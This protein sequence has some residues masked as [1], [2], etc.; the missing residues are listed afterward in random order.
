MITTAKRLLIVAGIAAVLL[1]AM[2]SAS[3]AQKGGAKNKPAAKNRPVAGT[4]AEYGQLAQ[5]REAV[6]RLAYVDSSAGKVTLNIDYPQPVTNKNAKRKGG[7]KP[8]GNYRPSYSAGRS[9]ANAGANLEQQRLNLVLQ[10]EQALA[11]RDPAQRARRLAEVAGEM[12]QLQA[13][14]ITAQVRAMANMERVQ[15]QTAVNQGRAVATAQKRALQKPPNRLAGVTTKQFELYT[16]A[17]V[18]IRRLNPPFEY[19]DKGYPRKFSKDELAALRGRNASVPGYAARYEDLEAGQMVKMY[20][21]DPKF[22]KKKEAPDAAGA[23]VKGLPV[24][25]IVILTDSDGRD[26]PALI[27]VKK[28]KKNKKN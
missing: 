19:D 9:S 6:G 5:L 21:A 20:L 10:E 4:A 15:L 16:A 26:T 2:P 3:V 25:M 22:A 8:G 12:E 17:N 7:S 24:R 11:I 14:A 1:P 13:Q 23:S 27:S 28:Q 18:V